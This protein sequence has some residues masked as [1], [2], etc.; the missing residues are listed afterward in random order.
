MVKHDLAA[1]GIDV[2]VQ[3]YDDWMERA[4]VRGAAYD[5]LDSVWYGD[6]AGS[7]PAG[8][9]AALFD[10]SG[11][12][13]SGNTNLAYFD[14]SVT[15]ARIARARRLRGAARYRAFAAIDAELTRTSAP[16]IAF[17]VDNVAELFS[18]RIG[19]RHFQPAYGSTS[20][21]ALCLRR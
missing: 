20:L 8:V 17:A 5:I 15:T 10:G 19:C 2:E 14:D 7:D 1:I 18:A 12:R 16:M 4:A 9:V 13:A 6:Y 11:L 21:A 3:Q